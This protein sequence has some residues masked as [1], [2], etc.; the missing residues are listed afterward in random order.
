[1][2]FI[3]IMVFIIYL[4]LFF[5]ARNEETN[6]IHS[7]FELL[8]CKV[9]QWLC[10]RAPI[11]Y[12][13]SVR[14]RE[15]LNILYPARKVNELQKEYYAE[16]TKLVLIIFFAGNVLVFLL[17][18]QV[19]SEGRLVDGNRIY[20]NKGGEGESKIEATAY[21]TTEEKTTKTPLEITVSEMQYEDE[22]VTELFEEVNQVLATEI[23]GENE[24]LDYVT[25]PLRL[26]TSYKSYPIKISWTSS[27][28]N[29]IDES[30]NV[31]NEELAEPV[32]VVLTA[33]LTYEEKVK[34]T[35][36]PIMVYEKEYLPEEKLERNL[37]K[38]IQEANLSSRL[39]DS[40]TL[41]DEI[42]GYS[43]RYVENPGSSPAALWMILLIC[44]IL[45]FFSKDS[46]LQEQVNE[47]NKM[48]LYEY[49]EFVS[50]LTLLVGAGMTV[51]GAIIRILKLY[52]EKK[53]KQKGI[54]YCYEE[55]KIA[56]FEIENGVYEEKAYE[57]FGKR[58]KIP[59]YIKLS[60]LLAQNI[61]KGT[62]D[63]VRLL[64]KEAEE[65]FEERKS[66]ARRQGEEAGTKLLVPM[67]MML[68][69]VMVL[70][71]VPAFLSY[72]V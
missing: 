42:E 71:I 50:K 4:I 61:K 62:R 23:A 59:S 32:V 54:N 5:L 14:V 72:Q 18:V 35:D 37:N 9:A 21:I 12:L 65:A 3:T 36:I 8:F 7:R 29:L 24:S 53:E 64:E 11:T 45:L 68:A 22:K 67:V 34:E 52:D 47:R 2:I 57:N 60:G 66:T 69:V 30:G 6:C 44:G 40:M 39:K 17:A 70:I 51:K 15:N 20:R 49:S 63:F 25:H 55:L 46:R 19:L 43:I 27:D 38:A 1:M 48:L 28:Y 16:K 56:I 13:M 33:R 58:C 26:I 31:N 41:P 10:R